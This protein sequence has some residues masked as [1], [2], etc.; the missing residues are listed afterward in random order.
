MGN[1]CS[2]VTTTGREVMASRCGRA[3]SGTDDPVGPFQLGTPSSARCHTTAMQGSGSSSALERSPPP[4][5]PG[6]PSPPC[7]PYSRLGTRPGRAPPPRSGTRRPSRSAGTA[8]PG[9]SAPRGTAR[10][11]RPGPERLGSARPARSGHGGSSRPGRHGAAQRPAHRL[12][13]P[14]GGRSGAGNRRRE[15][16]QPETQHNPAPTA[17]GRA[18]DAITCFSPLFNNIS[19]FL[20]TSAHLEIQN[21]S[22]LFTK[23]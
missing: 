13:L 6:P 7:S 1:N 23:K 8:A 9:T 18:P 12:R 2:Q 17:C 11:W 3:G 20:C 15:S 16:A 19:D 10:P 14:G 5:P 4:C 22:V 21:L